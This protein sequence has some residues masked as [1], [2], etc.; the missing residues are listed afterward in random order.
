MENSEV[1]ILV[2]ESKTDSQPKKHNKKKKIIIIF[3]G[4]VILCIVLT[5]LI[6]ILKPKAPEI[7]P[8]SFE[9]MFW[10]SETSDEAI[11]LFQKKIDATPEPEEKAELYNERAEALF[12]MNLPEIFK[13]QILE[14]A[15]AADDLQLTPRNASILKNYYHN[16]NDEE[17]EKYYEEEF[18]KRIEENDE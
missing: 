14:D 12:K 18:Y 6:I 10:D 13:N 11:E 2:E 7:D 1:N 8:R 3:S 16:F 17:K 9:E 4:L 5:I 15:L